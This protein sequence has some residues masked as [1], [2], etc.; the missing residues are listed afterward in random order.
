MLFF[1]R[2]AE[3]T[4]AFFNYC[5]KGSINVDNLTD[6]YEFLEKCLHR[7][8]KKTKLR[9][10]VLR[11]IFNLNHNELS[12]TYILEKLKGHIDKDYPNAKHVLRIQGPISQEDYSRY[13]HNKEVLNKL[14]WH[15]I[16]RKVILEEG[17]EGLLVDREKLSLHQA[18]DLIRGVKFAE[19]F[20]LSAWQ[21][22]R[23]FGFITGHQDL[24][25]TYQLYTD[26]T[27]SEKLSVEMP[28]NDMPNTNEYLTRLF[29]KSKS[30]PPPFIEAM[31]GAVISD[32]GLF[33][34]V[35]CGL[36]TRENIIASL[37]QHVISDSDRSRLEEII[38]EV[39]E[40]FHQFLHQIHIQQ[41][42]SRNLTYSISFYTGNLFTLSRKEMNAI[43]EKA[44]GPDLLT[45]IYLN[46]KDYRS[47]KSVFRILD[48]HNIRKPEIF[49][50][51]KFD[52]HDFILREY[53]KG[54]TLLEI[55]E[56][57][58][59]FANTVNILLHDSKRLSKHI[60]NKKIFRQV[61]MADVQ[62]TKMYIMD[63]FRVILKQ[64]AAF[65]SEFSLEGTQPKEFAIDD[66]SFGHLGKYLLDQDIAVYKD[67]NLKN[68]I[69]RDDDII[70]LDFELSWNRPRTHDVVKV[71][72]QLNIF[73]DESKRHLISTYLSE[74]ERLGSPIDTERFLFN[75]ALNETVYFATRAGFYKDVYSKRRDYGNIVHSWNCILENF[76]SQASALPR[77]VKDSVSEH[78]THL[79]EYLLEGEREEPK[80]IWEPFSSGSYYD[81]FLVTRYRGED[82]YDWIN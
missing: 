38:E 55:L 30:I 27:N 62:N 75:F 79:A 49:Y 9:Q 57:N 31:I 43:K 74:S 15:L 51:G 58:L 13:T 28:F 66:N 19:L 29:S 71:L 64:L 18:Q 33:R 78:L 7:I 53:I 68:W 20:N 39:D 61:S 47:E 37:P 44:K 76:G 52:E 46:E 25:S 63:I 21:L 45:K 54:H 34:K 14:R 65:H 35:I 67:S 77:E 80:V 42:K 72:N 2:K 5:D 10:E 70:P 69:M 3:V 56:E 6:N 17:L 41:N 50:E 1:K 16:G 32:K 48:E 60:P 8:G 82:W 36:L 26:I 22:S 81:I 24:N 73:S 59:R 4:E 40:G 11:H 23:I 12:K